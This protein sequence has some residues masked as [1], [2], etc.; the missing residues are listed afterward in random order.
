M[1]KKDRELKFVF[2]RNFG[3][4]TKM[5]CRFNMNVFLND[6]IWLQANSTSFPS[7]LSSLF[8]TCWTILPTSFGGKGPHLRRW[9][10]AQHVHQT[11]SYLRFSGVFLSYK[12]NARWSVQSPQDHFMITLIISDRRDW[13]DTQGKWHLARNPDRSW[14]HRHINWKFF[15]PQPMVPWTTGIWLQQ[16]PGSFH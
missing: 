5:G 3:L 4:T 1:A 12:A 9:L 7:F 2:N 6:S 11:V 14:W 10:V 15:W 13:R 8:L 16:P